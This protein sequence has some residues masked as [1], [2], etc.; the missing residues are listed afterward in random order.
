MAGAPRVRLRELQD[1]D[2]A[3][4]YRLVS[5]IRVVRFMLFPVFT[6]EMAREFVQESVAQSAG[7]GP[8]E[9][10]GRIVSLVRAIAFADTGIMIGLCGL[11]IER[12]RDQ[13]EAWY[14]LDPGYWGQGLT[15][16][17]AAQLLAIGFGQF[18]LHRIFAQCLPANPASAH[19]LKKLGMRREG[20]QRKNLRI[21]GEWHDSFLY[22]MLREEWHG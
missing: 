20:Y 1:C 15:T 5:D 9:P 13:G 6:E 8:D 17:A 2:V 14:L 19:V 21:H 3:A 11:G 10:P 12:D 22:A 16:E 7:T 4:V 18:R